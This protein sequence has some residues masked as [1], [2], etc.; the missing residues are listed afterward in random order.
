MIQAGHHAVG[1]YGISFFMTALKMLS[2]QSRTENDG[3]P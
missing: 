2:E 3:L 1:S